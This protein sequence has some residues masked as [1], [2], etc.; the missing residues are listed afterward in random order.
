MSEPINATK[1][2]QVGRVQVQDPTLGQSMR[3][4]EFDFSSDLSYVIH[5]PSVSNANT[6]GVPQ[7]IFV[8]NSDNDNIINV[9]VEGTNY[10][11]PVPAGAIGYFNIDAQSS[12]NI[13]LT[14][15]GNT[16]VPVTVVL[17]NFKIA[18]CVWYRFG[19]V[20]PDVAQA[21]K[22]EDG[23]TIMSVTN[24]FA[25]GG[26]VLDGAAV[27]LATVRPVFIAGVDR[28]DGTIRGVKVDA[29]GRMATTA[30]LTNPTSATA[31]VTAVAASIASVV[32]HASNAARLGA[33]IY[34][35]S[36]NVLYLLYGGG[37]ASAANYSVL[38]LAGATETVPFGYTGVISGA[39]GIAAGNARVTEFT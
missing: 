37:A 21:V 1:L 20:N 5:L 10:S 14:S 28:D 23:L 36:V 38:V 6:F 27:N 22:G 15:E 34:N 24:P 32:L 9:L 35:D 13:L 25:V 4:G 7:S 30:S 3:F 26:Q 12:S 29:Q 2:L 8:D 11:F 19:P 16:P 17:Y 33:M 39:W 18:P 31:T